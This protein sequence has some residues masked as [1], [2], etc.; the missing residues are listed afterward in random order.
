LKLRE[1]IP[2]SRWHNVQAAC[3]HLALPRALGKVLPVL[4]VNIA[5]DNAGR[6]L[7]LSLSRRDR[8][9]GQYPDLTP[10]GLQRVSE[11]N[12]IVVEGRAA[13]H[14]ATGV[15]SCR[16]RQVWE[17]DQAIN[18]HGVGID[19]DFVRAAKSIAEHAKGTL[20]DEFAELTGGL[21]PHQ[22]GATRE[23]L[24]GRGFPLEN[25]QDDTVHDALDN[26]IMPGDVARVLQIR[27][28]AA[29]TSLKK[30]DA[31]L[32]AV[33]AG[34]RARGL[35]QYHAATPGRWSA[36]LI[37]PQNLPRP[38]VDIDPGEIDEL[39][40]TVKTCDP[41]ALTRWGE[42]IEVLASA[43]RFAL[44][45]TDR[46]LFGVGDFAMIET[47]ILLG[48]AGQHDKCKLIADGV[49]IYRDM[50]ATIYG[51]DRDSFLAIAKDGLTL[52]QQQQR[53]AGKNTILGCGYQMGPQNFRQRYC[54][55]NDGRAGARHRLRALP[56]E[57]GAEGPAAW[58]DLEQTARRAMLQR[59]VVAKRRMRNPYRLESR[60]ACRAR[61]A[62]Y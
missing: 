7:V 58:R 2:I 16:E 59:G 50:A 32:N 37:Q 1:S 15:L 62:R 42:P 55:H 9:T 26:M 56:E 53:H 41:D 47:C 35:F 5:K 11:Y 12:R 38:T 57:L 4:G 29:P 24:K 46:A 31:M 39:V 20:V 61:S 44:T 54:R 23:W 10:D 13:S 49:D 28:I 3:S 14:A 43:L 19:T 6:R 60:L 40:A 36:Q 51:L 30:L 8:K 25:L 18:A 17:L 45:A 21:S 52:E 27:L 22:V 33:G 34:G 48:L